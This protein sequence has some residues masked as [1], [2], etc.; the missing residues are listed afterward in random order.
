MTEHEQ[1]SVQQRA[2][3]NSGADNWTVVE[4]G[5][6]LGKIGLP[7]HSNSFQRHR[8]TGKILSQLEEK[9]LI[10]MGVLLVGDRILV[11]GES[12]RLHIKSQNGM[13]FREVW[14]GYSPQFTEGPCDWSLQWCC[15]TPLWQQPNHY[16]LTAN[17][18][19]ITEVSEGKCCNMWGS[20]QLVR[21]IDL[22]NVAGFNVS[23]SQKACECGCAADYIHVDLH[24]SVGLAEVRAIKLPKGEGQDVVIRM[25]D[26]MEEVQAR[27][28]GRDVGAKGMAMKRL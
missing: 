1:Y 21:N 22:S 11:M 12:Q 10:E 16:K 28:A 5:M 19:I 7:E 3:D 23:S 14:A 27:E 24:E 15:C 6:W 13:R 18:L 25:M 20:K 17:S 9:H 26:T 8:I 2:D 4:V